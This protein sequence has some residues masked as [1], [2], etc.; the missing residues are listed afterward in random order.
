MEPIFANCNK[1]D[2]RASTF[3]PQSTSKDTPFTVGINGAN[4][5][6]STPLILPAINCP[7]TNTAPVLPAETNASASPAFIKFSA[8]TIE[9]SFFLRIAITGASSLVITSS[10]FTTLICSSE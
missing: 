5:G 10:A 4:G 9:E 8:T 7:P 6:L 3:A 2:G 1:W